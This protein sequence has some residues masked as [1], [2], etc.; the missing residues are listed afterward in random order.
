M[1]VN[2]VPCPVV[3][4]AGAERR[5]RSGPVGG[6]GF[7]KVMW[8]CCAFITKIW[9]PDNSS[10]L[11][12]HTHVWL[13]SLG[14]CCVHLYIQDVIASFEPCALKLLKTAKDKRQTKGQSPLIFFPPPCPL[15]FL[16]QIISVCFGG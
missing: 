7:S 2:T 11:V 6:I 15:S 12:T 14:E 5:V 10:S 3:A 13:V 16:L 1:R 4:F 8:T 9:C